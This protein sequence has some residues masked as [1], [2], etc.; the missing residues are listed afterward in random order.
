VTEIHDVRGRAPRISAERMA[1]R[2]RQPGSL[3]RMVTSNLGVPEECLDPE[4]HYHWIN[5]VRG[6]VHA[7]ITQD[8]Y[9]IVTMEELEANAQKRRA[10]FSLNREGYGNGGALRVP[11]ERDGTHAVLLKKPL[12]FY[13]YDYEDACA[14][15]QAMMEGRVYHGEGF[16]QEGHSGA[17]EGLD[18]EHT[19]V[20]QG[21]DLGAT[22]PRRRGRIPQRLK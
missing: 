7:M 2:R 19:Y 12:D 9:D 22:A 5:D 13:D 14:S 3:D 17:A 8:D 10:E 6:R 16:D 11:V 4:Y 15:R 1:R 18:E 20:P 21:N